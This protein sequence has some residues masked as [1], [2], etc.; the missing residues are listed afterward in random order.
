MDGTQLYSFDLRPRFLDGEIEPCTELVGLSLRGQRVD[1]QQ[2]PQNA[3]KI[4]CASI[5]DFHLHRLGPSQ[6]D[7]ATINDNQIASPH[8]SA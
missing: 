6:Q 2:F 1:F 3:L 8:M 5:P 4:F 7:I